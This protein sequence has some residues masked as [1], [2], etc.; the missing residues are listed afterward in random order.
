[1]LELKDI[2]VYYGDSYILQGVSLAV[3]R[4]GDR[5][6]AGTQRGR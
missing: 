3:T 1:M 2:H 5:L 4:G 6:P